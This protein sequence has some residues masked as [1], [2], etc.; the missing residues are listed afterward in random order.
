MVFPEASIKLK[1]IFKYDNATTLKRYVTYYEQIEMF[2]NVSQGLI[3]LFVG[4]LA[5]N[6]AQ[7]Y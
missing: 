5:Y 6:E 7:D 3:Y 2:T 1:L 4:L